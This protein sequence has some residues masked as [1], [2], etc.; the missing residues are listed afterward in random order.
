VAKRH[1]VILVLFIAP[2]PLGEFYLFFDKT[3]VTPWLYRGYKYPVTMQYYVDVLCDRL[4]GVLYVGMAFLFLEVRRL[5]LLNL[6]ATISFVYVCFDLFMYLVNHNNFTSY[7]FAYSCT[8]SVTIIIYWVKG[9]FDK[10]KG[11]L[12]QVKS[13]V[14]AKEIY[15]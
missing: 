4:I 8:L 5:F 7:I 10:L 11:M 6:A 14:E 15:Q 12:E 9:E 1:W 2:F 13:K 3:V